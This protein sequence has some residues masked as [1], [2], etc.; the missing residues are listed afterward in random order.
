MLCW[1][2]VPRR[3]KITV[4]L[5]LRSLGHVGS[6]ESHKAVSKQQPVYKLHSRGS[7]IVTANTNQIAETSFDIRVGERTFPSRIPTDVSA[8]V[9]KSVRRIE[10]EPSVHSL[11]KELTELVRE[12]VNGV[13]QVESTATVKQAILTYEKALSQLRKLVREWHSLID[14][15]AVFDIDQSIQEEAKLANEH[16]AKEIA[17]WKAEIFSNPLLRPMFINPV[18]TAKL[19]AGVFESLRDGLAED[20]QRHI[21]QF[22]ERMVEQL[23]TLVDLQVLGLVEWYGRNACTYHRFCRYVATNDT[24]ESSDVKIIRR[25]EDQ[26]WLRVSNSKTSGTTTRMLCR[27]EQHLIETVQLLIGNSGVVVPEAQQKIIDTIPFW[28]TKPVRLVEGDLIRE[29]IVTQDLSVHEWATESETVQ[30]HRDPAVV[31]GPFVLTSWGP[32]EIQSELKRRELSKLKAKGNSK[33]SGS[34]S[35]ETNVPLENAKRATT[36]PDNSGKPGA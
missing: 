33:G 23:F 9:E 34:E 32:A 29:S 22:S 19:A 27:N 7:I 26:R 3:N 15:I 1:K 14:L 30:Y 17:D 5:S 12:I 4:T 35:V 21:Q 28:L 13:G 16:T 24:T 10:I 11:G 36:P 2:T 18:L 8:N 31:L 25:P 20:V 6:I